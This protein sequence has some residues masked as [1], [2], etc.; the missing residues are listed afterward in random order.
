M[1]ELVDSLD[2]GSNAQACRFESCHPHQVKERGFRLSLLLY[3]VGSLEPIKC[4]SPVD[5]CRRRLDGGEPSFLP[6]A[7]M[8]IESCRPHQVKERG[9]RL[10]LL[11]YVAGEN[12]NAGPVV[13]K[14]TG[15]RWGSPL[16]AQTVK[17]TA[18]CGFFAVS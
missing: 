1:V 17:V 4:N 16:P 9:F 8:Q 11:L 12:C 3:V 13:R 6:M 10:S 14:R 18:L 5:C 7:K 15:N 2:L